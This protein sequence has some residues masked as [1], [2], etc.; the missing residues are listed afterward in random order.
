MIGA[1]QEQMAEGSSR[2]H[3]ISPIREQ[4][5]GAV[6]VEDGIIGCDERVIL[7]VGSEKEN[8]VGSGQL[9]ADVEGETKEKDSCTDENG[10]KGEKETESIQKA[11]FLVLDRM[12]E[13][14]EEMEGSDEEGNNSSS[15]IIRLLKLSSQ[16]LVQ[17]QTL[18]LDCFIVHSFI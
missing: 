16:V 13:G 8:E 18:V 7:I 5:G 17:E 12:V 4:T 6:R 1:L 2:N 10:N 9:D 14:G 3:I 11:L 15:L